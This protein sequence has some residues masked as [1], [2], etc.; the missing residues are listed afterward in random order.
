LGVRM[1]CGALI[2]LAPL[3]SR[4]GPAAD[5]DRQDRGCILIE[6]H[7]VAANA[8][9]IAVAAL[10]SLHVALARHG[11]AVKPSLHLLASVSGKGIDILRSAQ[12][13][14]DRLHER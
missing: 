11:V 13:E 12:R 6:D 7:P 2:A 9:T 4:R 3:V 5:V 10:K 8:E 14:D 1:I